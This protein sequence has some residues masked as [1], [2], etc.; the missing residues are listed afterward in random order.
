MTDAAV[1]ELEALV[2]GLNKRDRPEWNKVIMDVYDSHSAAIAL[3]GDLKRAVVVARKA[4]DI[5]G[6]ML[7]Q[8]PDAVGV[9]ITYANIL[10]CQA[11]EES[12]SI[13]KRHS[14]WKRR[15]PIP[16]ETRLRLDLNLSMARLVLGYRERKWVDGIES[17]RLKVAHDTLLS[18]FREAHPLGRLADAAA[19]ALLL[20]L[21]RVLWGKPDDIDWLSQSV[22]IALRARQLETLWRAYINLAHSLYRRGQSAHDAAA[23]AIDLMEFSLSSSSDSDSSPRFALLSVPMAH[24]TRY[25]IL[26]GD[27][28][29]DKVLRKFPAL[30]RMFSNLESGTLKDD[31]DGRVSHEWLRVDDADYVIF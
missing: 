16:D 20:G 7:T 3:A 26:S 24:A 17:G 25:L 13:L 4:A 29:V 6:T 30:R 21:I 18:V 8:S 12:E 23:A 14:V 2:A 11:P 5:A 27:K 15:H 19:A 31:R 1:S 9:I 10:L 22:A 28:K